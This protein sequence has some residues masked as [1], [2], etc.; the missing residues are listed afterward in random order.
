MLEDGR[1]YKAARLVL[2]YSMGEAFV[3]TA[4]MRFRAHSCVGLSGSRTNT[5]LISR[6]G[7]EFSGQS[8]SIILVQ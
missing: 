1:L 5:K 4:I 2:H 6:I 3:V 8:N 7:V